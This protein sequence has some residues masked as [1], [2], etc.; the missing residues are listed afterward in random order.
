MMGERFALQ[1]PPCLFM[2]SLTAFLQHQFARHCPAGWRCQHEVDLLEPSL[3]NLLGYAP[4]ADVLLQDTQHP[5][6]IWVEFEVSRADPV[7][8]HA[9]FATTHLYQ[10]WSQQDIFVA[11]VS[12]HVSRGR[13]NLAASMI[14]LMRRLGIQAFQTPLLPAFSPETIRHF[15][16]LKQPEL[17]AYSFDIATES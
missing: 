10:P 9:K 16:H 12:S 13:R 3:A 17:D 11:M 6:R 15:N 4:R 14:G 7:A 5:R 2:G 8:N 1:F